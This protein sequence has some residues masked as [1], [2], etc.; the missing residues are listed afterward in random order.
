MERKY[1]VCVIRKQEETGA[2][3]RTKIKI[4][5]LSRPED[6]EAV[7]EVKPDYAGFVVEVSKSR[8]NVSVQQLRRLTAL[9]DHGIVSVGVFVNAPVELIVGLLQ[10]GVLA[11]AQLHGQE[12]ETYIS[13]LRNRIKADAP[14]IQAFSIRTKE[15]VLRAVKSSADLI[16]LD[17]GSGG[18]GRTF[19]WSL[20][21]AV[22]RPFFLA[23]GLGSGNLAQAI[24]AVKPWAVDL[25]SA[26]ET[27]GYK[28]PKKMREAVQ[29]VRTTES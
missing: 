22:D 26:L 15:D 21:D 17:Q 19:D 28:D 5:G 3:Q 12:D 25:S 2:S 10:D 6:I 20:A 24:R 13:R 8:R 9:L 1:T 4:C 11:M 14:L 29:I 23:G 27:D 16:L 7:N 18:S